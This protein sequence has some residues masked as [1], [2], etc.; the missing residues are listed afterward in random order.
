MAR[1]LGMNP[2]RLPGLRP[3]PHQRW[4]LPVGEFIEEL[5]LKRFG[6]DA[7]DPRPH[8]RDQGSRTRALAQRDQ[9]APKHAVDAASQVEDLVCYLMNLTDAVH[10][11]AHESTAVVETFWRR[12]RT[13]SSGPRPVAL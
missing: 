8:A 5:Y 7:P 9:H 2:K 6:G 12:R 11:S 4:K 13:Q 3:S 10:R 1:A